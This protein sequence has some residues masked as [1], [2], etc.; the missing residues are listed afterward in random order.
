MAQEIT[1]LDKQVRLKQAKNGFRTSMDSVMLAAACPIKSGQMLLDM[2]CGVA[3]AGLCV[4]FRVKDVSLIG[5]DIQEDHVALAIENAALNSMSDNAEFICSDVRFF[6]HEKGF[7]HIV[8]NPPY[9]ETGAHL[10]SPHDAKATAMG[11]EGDLKT[12]DWVVNAARLLKPEGTLTMVHEAGKVDRILQAMEGRFGAI[13]IIPLWPKPEK[14]A[15]RVIIRAVKGRKSPL[16][17]HSGLILHDQGGQYT[18]EA[19]EILR[20]AKGLRLC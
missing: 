7:H 10:R 20:E 6:K 9:L 11:H 4:L 17:L 15:K 5:V 8:C 2:G 19:E 14:V 3:S 13:E 12:K 1:V 18:V 16:T